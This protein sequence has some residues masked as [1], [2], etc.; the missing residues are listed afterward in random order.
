METPR[1]K[2]PPE[3]AVDGFAALAA[4]HGLNGQFRQNVHLTGK[5]RPWP[6]AK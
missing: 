2:A 5:D 4:S 3:L 1:T 6:R